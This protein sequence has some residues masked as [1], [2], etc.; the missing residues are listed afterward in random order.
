LNFL[1]FDFF[2]FDFPDSV[3]LEFLDFN[4]SDFSPAIS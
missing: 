3:S 2:E 1:D 4:L